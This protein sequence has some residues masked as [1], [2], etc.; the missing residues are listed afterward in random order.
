[1]DLSW[2]APAIMGL[3]AVAIFQNA[4]SFW[5]KAIPGVVAFGLSIATLEAFFRRSN[6]LGVGLLVLIGS[7]YVFFRLGRRRS[8]SQKDE[9]PTTHNHYHHP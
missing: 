9:Q 7:A 1:M 5:A 3:L 2:M 4:K 6:W 8:K